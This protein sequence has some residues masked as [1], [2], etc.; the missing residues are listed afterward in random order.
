MELS[1]KFTVAM[2]LDQRFKLNFENYIVADNTKK[3]VINLVT[4]LTNNEEG[5]HTEYIEEDV[6][7]ITPPTYK[8]SSVWQHYTE[9]MHNIQPKRMST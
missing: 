3:Y 6:A 9:T 4:T 8:V 5:N 7:S 2:F 1:R